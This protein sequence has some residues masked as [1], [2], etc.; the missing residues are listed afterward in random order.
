MDTN[1]NAP[2]A[3]EA[4]EN[5]HTVNSIST[6]LAAQRARLLKHLREV[7]TL[8]TLQAREQLNIMHPGGRVLE[9]REAGHRITTTWTWD[10]DHEGRPH[11][12]GRYALVTKPLEVVA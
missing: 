10:R 11:R 6:S 9:L 12:V 5:D 3:G 8:T 4:I 2:L 1:K 7:G